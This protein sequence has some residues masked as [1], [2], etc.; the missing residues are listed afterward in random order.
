MLYFIGIF[1]SF[2]A[3][4]EATTTLSQQSSYTPDNTPRYLYK[5]LSVENW[6]KSQKEKAVVLTS[7]DTHFIHFSTEDQYPRIVEKYWKG[8][9]KYVLLKVETSKLPGRLVFETNPNGGTKYYHL[10]EGSIPLNAVVNSKV[11]TQNL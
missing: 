7:D 1:I 4:T 3:L 8:V 5:I 10:Y 2:F 11:I 6:E 9:P